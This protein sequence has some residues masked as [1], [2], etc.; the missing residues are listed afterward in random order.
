MLSSFS[1]SH[2]LDNKTLDAA[3]I[4]SEAGDVVVV[5]TSFLAEG[6]ERACLIEIMSCFEV[7]SVRK[8]H[9]C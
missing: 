9:P 1:F 6:M 3:S 8:L 7:T 2:L 4:S 5:G